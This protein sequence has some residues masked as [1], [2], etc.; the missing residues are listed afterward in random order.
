MAEFNIELLMNTI[1]L[2]WNPA[3]S[4][5]AMDDFKEMMADPTFGDYNWSVWDWKKAHCGDRFLMVRVGEEGLHGK[6]NGVVMSGYLTSEPY[7][8]GDWSGKGREVYYM[9]FQPDYIFDT[10]KVE[11]LTDD[12]LMEAFPQFDW[13]KGHSGQ[14]LDTELAGLVEECWEKAVMKNQDLLDNGRKWRIARDVFKKDMSVRLFSEHFQSGDVIT[15]AVFFGGGL[16]VGSF[17]S[18][19]VI[20]GQEFLPDFP[21]GEVPTSTENYSIEITSLRKALGARDDRELAKI[22]RRDYTGKDGMQ[23]LLDFAK[24]AGCRIDES[25]LY[26]D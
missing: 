23:K 21:E 20:E 8:G 10:E 17:F 19:Y 16:D 22:L 7:R 6:G 3:I 4:S 1:I 2:M 5:F 12:F 25:V 15:E 9:D 24:K 18:R 11:T 13:T 26:I 14:C